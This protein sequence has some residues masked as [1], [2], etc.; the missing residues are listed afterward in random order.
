MYL[1]LP[2]K[3]VGYCHKDQGCKIAYK[4]LTGANGINEG[5]DGSIW[6]ANN[7]FSELFVFEKEDDNTLV[8]TDTLKN[9]YGELISL[10]TLVD[11]S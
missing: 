6:V 4:G 1:G 5:P 7:I 2:G 8:L 10:H 9:E 11:T 3:S